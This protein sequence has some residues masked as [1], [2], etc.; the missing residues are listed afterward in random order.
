MDMSNEKEYN[1]R[2][3][4]GE[5]YEERVTEDIEV[6]KLGKLSSQKI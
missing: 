6:S 4:I 1:E 2:Y 5:S 3:Q